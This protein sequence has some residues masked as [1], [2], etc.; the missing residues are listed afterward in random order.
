M[1]N[2][3][4]VYHWLPHYRYGVFSEIDKFEPWSTVFASD[5]ESEGGILT[6]PPAMLCDHRVLRN[7]RIGPLM[8][9]RG[10]IR[11]SLSREFERVVFLGD[12]SF[13]ST[14]VAAAIL[15][16]RGVPVFFWTIG[17][18]R[19]EAGV[20]RFVRHS[21]YRLA[22]KLLLYGNLAKAIGI[23]QGFPAERLE[24]IYNSHESFPRSEKPESSQVSGALDGDLP[25]VGA[26]V[27]LSEGKRLD[28]LIRAAA[29]LGERGTPVTVLLAGEGPMSGML[30]ELGK[31]L[32]VDVR[33][34]GAVY[35][36]DGLSNLYSRLS[37][38]VV[39]ERAGLTAIQS[40]AYGVPVISSDE[41]Y[42][43]M[44][45]W[46]SIVPG[47]TG[48]YFTKGS[49]ES[50]ADVMAHWIRRM[51]LE[52]ASVGRSCKSEVETRWAPVSHALNIIRAVNDDDVH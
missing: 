6:I 20:K 19:P 16:V 51:R 25:A 32:G 8:W 48:D 27:R 7:L 52:R 39:P 43:Q 31:N 42:G 50:L 26:V 9:Q 23:E 37:L 47:Q 22:N 40:L 14:W 10:L 21:F 46:E 36:I 24:V 33:L 15:R 28:L 38:T 41:P 18:H 5:V 44:P 17:W 35:D 1:K 30:Y 12:A 3:L 29:I 45:E 4:M 34:L 49:T 11:L 13:V 2:V